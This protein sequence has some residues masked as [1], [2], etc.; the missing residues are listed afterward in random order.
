LTIGV[1]TFDVI[2]VSPILRL[3]PLLIHS[4]PEAV[5]REKPQ[6]KQKDSQ[7]NLSLPDQPRHIPDNT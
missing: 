1:G 3:S 4:T 6:Y 2:Y 5:N 7:A